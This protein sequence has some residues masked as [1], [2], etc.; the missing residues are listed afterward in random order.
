[1]TAQFS[2]DREERQSCSEGTRMKGKEHRSSRILK[3]V[4]SNNEPKEESKSG[5][6]QDQRN[7]KV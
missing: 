5:A 3:D 4:W 1:M 2:L 7:T 6:S